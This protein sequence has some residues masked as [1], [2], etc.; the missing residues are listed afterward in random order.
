[1]PTSAKASAG[2]KTGKY[3]KY[4]IGEIILVVIGILIALQINNWNEEQKNRFEEKNLLLE[5]RTEFREKK[6]RLEANKR[7]GDGLIKNISIFYTY[8]N[9]TTRE[10]DKD[11][12]RFLF[13]GLTFGSFFITPNSTLNSIEN[14]A[15]IYLIKNHELRNYFKIWE[16]SLIKLNGF[17]EKREA[18]IKNDIYPI[19]S[20]YFLFK[21]YAGDGTSMVEIIDASNDGKGIQHFFNAPSNQNLVHRFLTISYALYYTGGEFLDVTNEVLQMIDEEL[22]KYEDIK[23]QP[24][25]S[26]IRVRGDAVDNEMSFVILE[27]L[28]NGTWEGSV[29]LKDGTVTFSNRERGI[30]QWTGYEFPKGKLQS[31]GF[32]DN[33]ISV[34]KGLYRV[35][36]DYENGTYEFIKIND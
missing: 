3:L 22:M 30:I 15:K 31:A 17:D 7:Q 27:K 18:L 6:E 12:L 28:N 25:F 8:A 23:I 11:S 19:V 10:Y 29:P 35:I 26:E 16:N 24:Y 4:A 34:K 20:E 1:N 13:H 9:S 14:S 36:F 33:S 21:D 32:W 5:L 2:M